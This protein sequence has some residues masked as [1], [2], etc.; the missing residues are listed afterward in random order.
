MAA[1]L[2]YH[3]PIIP[4][5]T[6]S[7]NQESI[8]NYLQGASQTFVQGAPVKMSSGAVVVATTGF[9]TSAPIVGFAAL[10]G[11][12]LSSAGKGASPIFGSIGFPGGT[13]TYGSVPNQ[14]S[15]VNLIH[16][17]VFVDGLMPVYQAV[18][19]TIF[20][21]QVDNSTGTSG[22]ATTSN[23]GQYAALV[24]DTNSNWYLDLNT[25]AS[26]PGTLP[27]VIVGLNPQDFVAGSTTTQQSCGRAWIK[28]L[29]AASAVQ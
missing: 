19:D 23:I 11:Q 8:Y 26:S 17:A 27:V 18:E 24:T 2:S 3:T 4:I 15:A 16:G 12:N 9:S 25:A 13:P 1:I 6:I 20:E 28:V 7:G 14:S 5:K 10:A 22:A 29:P 21:V